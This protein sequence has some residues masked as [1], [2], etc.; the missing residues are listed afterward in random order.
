MIA[1]IGAKPAI[2]VGNRIVS[3]YADGWFASALCQAA[4]DSPTPPPEALL[5]DLLS[6]FN[7]WLENDCDLGVL[8]VKEFYRH[9]RE[10]LVRVG[11]GD[12]ARSLSEIPPEV[13]FD[14]EDLALSQ[15]L[16]LFFFA[17]LL[18]ELKAL[19]R[20]G[21]R[22]VHFSGV[23]AAASV[24]CPDPA[25]GGEREKLT[26]AQKR[27]IRKSRH[28]IS[29]IYSTIQELLRRWE[30]STLPARSRA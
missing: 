8:S 21:A 9:L 20:D 2:R 23:K 1:M 13:D 3:H 25:A 15:K 26:A 16:P 18:D 22:I 14:L 7:F 19:H 28:E 5:G 24:L 30:V 4:V 17:R 10:A 12:L 6:A 29:Q 27:K 11:M